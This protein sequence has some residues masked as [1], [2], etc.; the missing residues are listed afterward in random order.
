ML[1]MQQVHR[2]TSQCSS[3]TVRQTA[4]GGELVYWRLGALTWHVGIHDYV[5]DDIRSQHWSAQRVAICMHC[6]W[7]EVSWTGVLA[8][9]TLFPKSP[10]LALSN[11][12]ARSAG[13]DIEAK[14]PG[15]RDHRGHSVEMTNKTA[16]PQHSYMM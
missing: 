1:G 8:I 4:R 9:N 14:P 12:L 6:E 2:L 10:W 16:S 7:Q 13:I 11:G 15:W 3:Y 5:F